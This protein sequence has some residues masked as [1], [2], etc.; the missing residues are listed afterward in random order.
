MVSAVAGE[1]NGTQRSRGLWPSIRS[2]N[3]L[4]STTSV[5]CSRNDG[6]LAVKVGYAPTRLGNHSR[7]CSSRTTK[8]PEDVRA[9]RMP[10]RVGV[11]SNEPNRFIFVY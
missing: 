11:A 1:T 2:A 9:G 4:S 8:E 7:E 6:R 3:C 10:G 5:A